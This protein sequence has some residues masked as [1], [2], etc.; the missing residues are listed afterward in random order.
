MYKRH[1]PQCYS[2]SYSCWLYWCWPGHIQNPRLD[3]HWLVSPQADRS[4]GQRCPGVY[5]SGV[6]HRVSS[7]PTGRLTPST[8]LCTG[9]GGVEND[10]KGRNNGTDTSPSPFAAV[11]PRAVL[12]ATSLGV[13]VEGGV[14]WCMHRS[15]G[16]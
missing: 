10:N 2:S 9:K 13:C 12:L 6:A 4:S 1:L 7:T 16:G 5:V 11:W 15:Y 8:L 14:G 3:A